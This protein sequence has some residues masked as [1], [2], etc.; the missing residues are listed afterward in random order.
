[1]NEE[2]RLI[3]TIYDRIETYISK[4]DKSAVAE[5]LVDSFLEMGHEPEDLYEADGEYPI[6]DAAIRSNIDDA[7]AEEDIFGDRY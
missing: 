7:E 6:L 4:S 3:A 1:M 5:A 2:A